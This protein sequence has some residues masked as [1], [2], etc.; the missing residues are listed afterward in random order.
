MKLR[1]AITAAA[2]CGVLAASFA[3]GRN[4]DPF[5][6]AAAPAEPLETAPAGITADSYRKAFDA[7]VQCAVDSGM[8]MAGEVHTSRFGR[9]SVQLTT[10]G[11]TGAE[12]AAGFHTAHEACRQQHL[13]EAELA[14]VLAHPPSPEEAAEARQLTADCLALEGMELPAA[15]DRSALS[16]A[17]AR[18]LASGDA[19]TRRAVGACLDA[20]AHAMNWPGYGGS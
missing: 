16:A 13:N 8:V 12:A 20:T 4:V 10:P 5:G 17:I 11:A 19:D 9:L 7:Y 15:V 18:G 2:A 14:W 6:V 3:L 1:I